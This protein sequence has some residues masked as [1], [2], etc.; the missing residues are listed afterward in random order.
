[1]FRDGPTYLTSMPLPL[2]LTAALMEEVLSPRCV[3]V[4]G[5]TISLSVTGVTLHKTGQ[6]LDDIHVSMA[7]E[8]RHLAVTR[9]SA[10]CVMRLLAV[11]L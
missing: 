7:I 6:E 1:M 2:S 4:G 11:R 3:C 5:H 8:S 10:S 9:D